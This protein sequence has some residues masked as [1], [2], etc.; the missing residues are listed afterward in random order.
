[1][2]G[3]REDVMA[4]RPRIGITSCSKNADYE[5]SV[6]RAGGEPV[7]LDWSDPK[8]AAEVLATVD[9]VLMTGGPDVDPALYGEKR[10][11]QVVSLAPPARDHFELELARE[12]IKQDA[13]ILAICR[14]LQVLNVAA[15]GSLVQDIPTSLPGALA[16]DVKDPKNA[17]AHTVRIA[18]GSRIAALLAGT[19]TRVNSRHHQAVKRVGNGLEVTATAPDGIVEALEKPDARFCVAVEWHPENFVETGEFLPLFEALVRASREKKST[20]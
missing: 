12:V 10:E 13:P 2:P 3:A 7:I 18:P 11:P 16:H 17:I 19:E 15:G 4:A 6:R 1:M 20:A 9:G 5:E 8:N 14:G